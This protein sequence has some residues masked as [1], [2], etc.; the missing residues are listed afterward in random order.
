M[1]Y[2]IYPDVFPGRGA[3]RSAAPQTRG[4]SHESEVPDQQ[5]TAPLRFALHRIRDTTVFR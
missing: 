1:K 2:P 5:C 3:A 4:P